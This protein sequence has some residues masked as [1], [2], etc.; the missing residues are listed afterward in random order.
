MANKPNPAPDGNANEDVEAMDMTETSVEQPAGTNPLYEDDLMNSSPVYDLPYAYA[1][2]GGSES[3]E[4]GRPGTDQS[5][6]D[7]STGIYRPPDTIGNASVTVY[8]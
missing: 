5:D 8:E 1:D 6:P 4:S 3:L 2:V 7:G